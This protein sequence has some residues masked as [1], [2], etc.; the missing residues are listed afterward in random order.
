MCNK[1]YSQFQLIPALLLLALF[2]FHVDAVRAV[3]VG[4]VDDF[5]DTTLQGWKK[6]NTFTTV[7][8]MGNVFT[9]GPAGLGDNYLG[10][11]ADGDPDSGGRITIINLTQWTGDYLTAGVNS[12]EMDLNNFGSTDPVSGSTVPLNIRLAFNGDGGVFSTSGSFT[13]D[14]DS[15]WLHAVFPILPGDLTSVS[16]PAAGLPGTDAF[17]TLGNVSE[18]RLLNSDVASWSGTPVV[19]YVGID[20]ITAVSTVPLP[21]SAWLFISGLIS[22][23]LVR[24]RPWPTG[25]PRCTKPVLDYR[26]FQLGI[27]GV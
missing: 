15:G 7:N 27:R 23:A 10:S 3:T 26:H 8:F 12:I 22:L 21:P 6:G 9:G 13:L 24:L 18:L 1:R 19:A 4:Q 16:R 2:G 5:E 25:D 14:S 17:A 20:N 11:I